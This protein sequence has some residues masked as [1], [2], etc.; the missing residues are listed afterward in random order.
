VTAGWTHRSGFHLAQSSLG[1]ITYKSGKMQYNTK[2]KGLTSSRGDKN[3]SVNT[4]SSTK[5]VFI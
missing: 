5:N 4:K 1:N 3:L 2:K